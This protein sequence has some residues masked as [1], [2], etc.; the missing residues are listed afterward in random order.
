MGVR[1]LDFDDGFTSASAPS[2]STGFEI[3]SVQDIAASGTITFNSA[4][5]QVLKVQGDGGA[6]TASNTPFGT[7]PPTSGTVIIVSGSSDTNT[8]TL[9]HNDAAN[10]CILNGNATLGE[11]DAITL[12][13]NST[14]D[15]YEEL[16]RN[17]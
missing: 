8:V 10:G 5:N 7:T 11:Y 15:R 2:E 1:I 16:S 4:L 3:S 17:F 14:T 13:Y 9:T 12:V 6:V